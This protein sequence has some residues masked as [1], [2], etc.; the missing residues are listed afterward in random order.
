MDWKGLEPIGAKFLQH[1]RQKHKDPFIFVFALETLDDARGILREVF[2]NVDFGAVGEEGIQ[3]LMKWKADMLRPCQRQVNQRCHGSFNFLQH[4][5]RSESKTVRDHFEEIVRDSPS[6]VLEMARR[7]LKHRRDSKGTQREG[8]EDCLGIA[9]CRNFTRSM[10]AGEPAIELLPDPNRA[11]IRVFGSRRSQTLHNRLRA[12]QKF[13][14]WLVAFSG[15]VWPK[16]ITPLVA[17]VEERIDEGCAYTC[18]GE[19]HASLSILEQVGRV[20]RR[21]SNDSTWLAH[22]SSWKLELETNARVPRPAKPYT[23]ATL[24]SL[25]VFLI[26]VAQD[27]YFRFIAWVM[28]VASWC[29]FRDVG[30][31]SVLLT[32]LGF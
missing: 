15:E 8:T 28:L 14:S 24:A 11:W 27:S 26:D 6:Y 22:L 10:F 30:K 7:Q 19:L 5:G 25:E 4:P 13:R 29:S 16:P 1:L 23:V 2:G 12:W 17:F 21:I 31:P 3:I 32:A 20:P 9:T 18:P